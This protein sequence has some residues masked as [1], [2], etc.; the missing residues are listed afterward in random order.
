MELDYI[1]ILKENDC[2]SKYFQDRFNKTHTSVDIMMTKLYKLGFVKFN[3]KKE[4]NGR[5]FYNSRNFYLTTLG[6]KYVKI[7][8]L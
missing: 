1:K 3:N 2:T 7:M 6:N 4:F 8:N 5:R